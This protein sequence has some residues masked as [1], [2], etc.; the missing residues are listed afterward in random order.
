MGRNP[1][2]LGIGLVMVL[3]FSGCNSGEGE[4]SKQ[5]LA[6]QAH[7]GID[8]TKMSDHQIS[9]LPKPA[10]DAIRV[11]LAQKGSPPK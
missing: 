7:H 9:M 4:P 3:A 8:V 5:Q 6:D 10:Q 1:L 11:E 2:S